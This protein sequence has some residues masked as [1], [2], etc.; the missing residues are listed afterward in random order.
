M[1]KI[2]ICSL[3]M[4]LMACGGGGDD[5]LDGNGNESHQ[6]AVTGKIYNQA[7]QASRN[8]FILNTLHSADAGAITVTW[9]WVNTPEPN[10]ILNAT[11]H[12]AQRLPDISQGSM[13]TVEM[14]VKNGHG[15]KYDNTTYEIGIE[16][17]ASRTR[18]EW[19]CLQ[20]F[21]YGP[22]SLACNI[23]NTIH[24][25]YFYNTT[26]AP[27]WACS[28]VPSPQVGYCYDVFPAGIDCP[29]ESHRWGYHGPGTGLWT[30][31]GTIGSLLPGNTFTTAASYSHS[32][33]DIRPNHLAWFCVFDNEGAIL[34]EK[35]YVL[36][37][38][39]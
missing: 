16:D 15:I 3:I 1:K 30:A 10:S 19:D 22:E 27:G 7:I 14:F 20:C 21:D 11:V 5:P 23:I 25:G 37:V 9:A 29:S 24:G 17:V 39:Q 34:T 38:T 2:I 18:E 6:I 31:S 32:A 36:D 33:M 35:H 4:A 8:L 13:V 26:T 12:D 28:G